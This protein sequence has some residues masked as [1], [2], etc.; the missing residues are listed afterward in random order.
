VLA[1][2][3]P[4]T[5]LEIRIRTL[6]IDKAGDAAVAVSIEGGVYRNRLVPLFEDLALVRTKKS[7]STRFLFP[8]DSVYPLDMAIRVFPPVRFLAFSFRDPGVPLDIGSIAVYGII[9]LCP[10]ADIAAPTVG[11]PPE[12]GAIRIG[13][14]ISNDR[15]LDCCFV[16]SPPPSAEA[17]MPAELILTRDNLTE[18]AP[19]ETAVPLAI[20]FR[21][22][23]RIQEIIIACAAP[24]RVSIP[25]LAAL[26]FKPPLTQCTLA[27]PLETR[28]RLL[29]CL[30]TGERIAI[31]S[32][33]F[34]G[35]S[36]A[37][38]YPDFSLAGRVLPQEA[39]L[40]RVRTALEFQGEY[41]MVRVPPDY[42]V[43]GLA[44]RPLPNYGKLEVQYRRESEEWEIENF[45][46]PADVGHGYLM[47][48]N[49]QEMRECRIKLIGLRGDV[50]RP[51]EL[52]L[53]TP[54]SPT[55]HSSS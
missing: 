49:R 36:I 41:H 39:T 46:L 24:V 48:A 23:A 34:I 14:T 51:F 19:V 37:P 44:F 25:E 21:Y 8:R 27:C 22:E 9:D 17:A 3:R 13:T 40:R 7:E 20:L 10:P 45:H 28:G 53:L 2:A 31:V 6:E 47:L 32:L 50:P 15:H 1:L 30:L 16:D 55:T 12:I 29:N 33:T 42:P 26:T 18:W 54:H 52:K 35:E 11:R 5:V 43:Y 38:D 4:A